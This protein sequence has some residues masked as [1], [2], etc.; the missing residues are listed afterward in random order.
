[1][2]GRMKKISIKSRLTLWFSFWMTLIASLVLV[3][4]FSIG[5][6]FVKNQAKSI[7]IDGVEGIFDHMTVN[8]GYLEIKDFSFFQDGLYLSVYDS[9]GYYLEGQIPR[10][11]NNDLYFVEG[12]VRS[13]S[14][15]A[16]NSTWYVFDVIHHVEG[17]GE[18][19][20]R[21]IISS[22]QAE[23]AVGTLFELAIFIVPAI[24]FL[25][26][27]G[28]YI[29]A[30]RALR[31]IRQLTLTTKEIQ[32]GNDLSKRIHL[33]YG[34]DEIYILAQTIDDMFDRLQTSF[35]SERQFTSDASHELRT[36][37]S[38]IIAQCEYTLENAETKKDYQD[39]LEIIF[40][41]TN[42]MSTLVSQLLLLAR[43]DQN[44]FHLEEEIINFSELVETT[45]LL[46]SE[47]END[48]N[49]TIQAEIEPDI[50][51]HADSTLMMR[52]VNNLIDNSIKYGK[53]NGMT[54]LRLSSTVTDI[55]F[56]VEDN[57]IGIEEENIPKIFHRFYQIESAR[58]PSQ[59]L[60]LGLSMVQWIVNIHNGSI[61][62]KSEFGKGST[63]KIL[64][65]K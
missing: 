38:V 4:L 50:Y 18:V 45:V 15:S 3:L 12:V 56:L 21:G 64:F 34:K 44:N 19:W 8:N 11:F 59:G 1:M 7:L 29:I 35:E 26:V 20:V 9:Q 48:K 25:S 49:I 17:F 55:I 13:F 24:L 2:R 41:H 28:G 63:F 6:V 60:G 53:E 27:L 46:Y 52:M 65:K 51:F 37:I 22:G 36:P 61:E 54:T 31:P 14:S 32:S 39:A 58:E 23:H 47:E 57:G 33:G 16:N 30:S 5:D 43:L 10:S 62:V 40:A 42:K